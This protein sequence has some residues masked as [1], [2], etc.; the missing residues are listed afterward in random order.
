MQST[1]K[2]SLPN[3][4]NNVNINLLRNLILF[5]NQGEI[6]FQRVEFPKNRA[7]P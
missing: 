7:W 3:N 5:I 1:I 4:D 2:L 6:T